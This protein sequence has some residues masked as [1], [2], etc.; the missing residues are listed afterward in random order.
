MFKC[1]GTIIIFCFFLWKSLMGYSQ[2]FR[3]DL[4]L[5]TQ[6]FYYYQSLSLN[7]SF[8]SYIILFTK[9]E[10]QF[11]TKHKTI[12]NWNISDREGKTGA[13]RFDDESKRGK[14]IINYFRKI[15]KQNI[16]SSRLSHCGRVTPPF[17][18]CLSLHRLTF[19]KTFLFPV[20]YLSFTFQFVV[21]IPSILFLPVSMSKAK[22]YLLI[23]ISVS[24]PSFRFQSLSLFPIQPFSFIFIVYHPF[25]FCFFLFLF[26]ISDYKIYN[27]LPSRSSFSL[28]MFLHSYLHSTCHTCPSLFSLFWF[29]FSI[30]I[31]AR[32]NSVLFHNCQIKKKKISK[33]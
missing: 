22:Q 12:S 2:V 28:T 3:N 32:F 33:K 16:W 21:K 4:M 9:Y 31:I 27:V 26:S 13:N 8:K 18:T 10:I 30:D 29:Y 6:A 7:V 14:K 17:S 15:K 19:F 1:N 24:L 23:Y 11:I 5:Q 25:I 20:F